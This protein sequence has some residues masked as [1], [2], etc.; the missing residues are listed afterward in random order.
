M[1][2]MGIDIGTYLYSMG[3]AAK[4]AD[5][6]AAAADGA[7]DARWIFLHLLFSSL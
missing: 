2:W 4:L 1:G 5:A 7:N 3:A 6:R